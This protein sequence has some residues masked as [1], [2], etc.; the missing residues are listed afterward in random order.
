MIERSIG[1][2][3]TAGKSLDELSKEINFYEN[4]KVKSTADLSIE[5]IEDGPQ[6]VI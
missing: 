2:V 4:K 6:E 3:F 1:R 5:G